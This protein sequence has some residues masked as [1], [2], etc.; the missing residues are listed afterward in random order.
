MDRWPEEFG[1]RHERLYQV[2]LIALRV[3]RHAYV[4]L[5][6]EL[7]YAPGGH[8]PKTP[9]IWNDARYGYQFDCYMIV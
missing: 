5:T 7:E 4:W 6:I 8:V 9:R 2:G 3:Q 1:G